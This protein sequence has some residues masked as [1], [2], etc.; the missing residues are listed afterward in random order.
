MHC[1]SHFKSSKVSKKTKI[2]L[3]DEATA[4]IDDETEK[5]IVGAIEKNLASCTV[6]TVAHRIQTVIKSDLF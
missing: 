3:M 4:A 2:V 5:S 6:I 1:K